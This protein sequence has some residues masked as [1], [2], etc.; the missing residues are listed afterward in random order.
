MRLM[1]TLLFHVYNK[2]LF[3]AI[4]CNLLRRTPAQKDFRFYR[5]YGG[6]FQKMRSVQKTAVKYKNSSKTAPAKRREIR[7]KRWDEEK[8]YASLK[9]VKL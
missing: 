7:K 4:R 2:E 8:P 9:K 6:G 3:P 5:G 1:R